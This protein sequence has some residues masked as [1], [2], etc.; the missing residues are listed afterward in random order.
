MILHKVIFGPVPPRKRRDAED[1]IDD[2]IC[3]LH[4]NGQAVGEYFQATQNGELCA[5]V[6]LSG[7]KA[8]SAKYQSTRASNRLEK[9]VAIFN[10]MP[11]WTVL[12]DDVPKSD[13]TWKGAPF[14]Y[15]F[16][17][18][19]S[20]WGSPLCRGDNR[21]QIPL[22]RIACPYEVR[23]EIYFWQRAYCDHDAI[24]I[25]SSKLEI[26]AYR[27]LAMPDS[28]LSQQGR[29]VCRKVESA[30]GVPTYYYLMRYWGRKDGED[31]RP[32]PGCGRP[33]HLKKPTG[34]SNRFHDFGFRCEKCR[35][36]SHLAASYDDPRHASIGEW[37]GTGKRTRSSATS[38]LNKHPPTNI[39]A[40]PPI[41]AR[42][43]MRKS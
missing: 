11:I 13:P 24:W 12:D 39:L 31:L 15:L 30:T 4:H 40:D 9:L 32:C 14:L 20:D 41:T 34:R 10:Q 25:G 38:A 18:M 35:L 7:V 28:E 21:K 8:L 23:E 43:A 33:W 27:Q 3:V 6:N 1:A 42:L 22:Y 37:Q 16:T 2:Y 36:V 17:C 26:P 29:D 19:T 5:Y